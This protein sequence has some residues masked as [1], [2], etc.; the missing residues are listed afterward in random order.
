MVLHRLTARSG[1]TPE[2]ERVDMPDEV[3]AL[4]RRGGTK[5][6]MLD[7]RWVNRDRVIERGAEI[8]GMDVSGQFLG[9]AG[10]QLGTGL[11]VPIKP[12][13]GADQ[14]VTVAA[15]AERPVRSR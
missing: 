6:R 15:A 7:P 2:L 12:G 5:V 8:V 14:P 1:S 3:T 13:T 9:A 4:G 10:D 11:P